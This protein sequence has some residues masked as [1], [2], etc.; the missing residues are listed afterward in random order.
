MKNRRHKRRESY[1]VLFVSN[2]DRR[3]RRF[4]IAR[5]TLHLL[6]ILV[7]MVFAAAG[8]FGY[9]TFNNVWQESSLQKKLRDRQLAEQQL[10]SEWEADKNEWAQEKQT[11]EDELETLR[12]ELTAREQEIQ[13]A[14]DAAA[15]AAAEAER[16]AAEALVP[17]L[18]PSSGVGVL[19]S[20]FSEEHPY[21]SF[22]VETGTDIIAAGDGTV[23]SV[24]SD[25]TY[26][27]IIEVVHDSG[28]T[29]YYLYRQNA[30][31]K[32]EEGAQVKKGDP[33]L[34]ITTENTE[35]DYE[36]LYGDEFIDPLSIIAAKG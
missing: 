10:R 7:L 21:I 12:A 8:F 27:Y 24:S 25:D 26:H 3:S 22:T 19:T 30:D 17:T 34:T 35:L 5:S 11:L 2:I 14:A 18:Y 23:R 20:T 9:Q 1:S 16:A 29:T 33:L 13:A 6:V 28:H 15:E 4:R 32:V 31:L 36:V